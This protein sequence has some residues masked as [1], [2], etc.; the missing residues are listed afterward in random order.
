[1]TTRRRILH[2]IHERIGA[3]GGIQRFDLR[4]LRT[5]SGIAQELGYEFEVLALNGV[6]TGIALP[7]AIRLVTAD[8]SRARLLWLLLQRHRRAQL[9]LVFVAH[10]RLQKAL[11]PARLLFPGSRYLLFVHGIEAW[12]AGRTRRNRLAARAIVRFCV[13]DVVSV[14]RFTARRFRDAFAATRHRLH[15]LPNAL[16]LSPEDAQVREPRPVMH[17]PVVLTVAR[18]D[19][20][21]LPKG[22]SAALRAIALLVPQFPQLRYRIVGDGALRSG[23]EALAAELGL[24]TRVEFLGRVAEQA[25]RSIY[26]EADV[27]LLPSSK[28]GFGIVFLEAWRQALPVVCGNVDASTEVVE[29]GVDGFTVDPHDPEAIARALRRLLDDAVLRQTFGQRGREKV[30][31]DYSGAV[32]AERLQRIVTSELAALPFDSLPGGASIDAERTTETDPPRYSAAQRW[33]RSP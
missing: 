9:D 18:M 26:D 12:S 31:R 10:L 28:E 24:Q 19:P 8:G 16:D 23:Y 21:D 5:L 6:A 25:L 15:L 2:V 32:F 7:E 17:Q 1:M 30:A 27:F 20:H 11:W 29:D 13:D 14:S 3:V 4:V 22:I 33:H